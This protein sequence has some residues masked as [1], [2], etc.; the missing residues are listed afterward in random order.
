MSDMPDAEEFKEVMKVI[1]ETV[2]ELLDKLNKSLY[3]PE[4]TNYAKAVAEF[5]KALRDEGMTDEQAFSLTQQYM[6]NMSVGGMIG[7]IAKGAAEEHHHDDDLE[8]LIRKRVKEE[9]KREKGD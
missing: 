1:S 6:S 7:S 8:H 2:P 3:G 9:L 4:G 5:Y